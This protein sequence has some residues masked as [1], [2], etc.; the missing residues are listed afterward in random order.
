MVSPSS[1]L[2]A[3]FAQVQPPPHPLWPPVHTSP[4]AGTYTSAMHPQEMAREKQHGGVT[5]GPSPWCL[6][7]AM[8][9][10]ALGQGRATHLID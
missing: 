9:R 8:P 10:H 3:V 2:V 6:G 7:T 4:W 5:R 1:A